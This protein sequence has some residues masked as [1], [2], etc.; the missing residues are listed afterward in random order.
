[1]L[2]KER[3]NPNKNNQKKG[4]GKTIDKLFSDSLTYV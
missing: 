2:K 4:E 3:K 1:M